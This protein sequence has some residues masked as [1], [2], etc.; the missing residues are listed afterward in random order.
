MKLSM[1]A[2]LLKISKIHEH[3]I[4]LFI[5]YQSPNLKDK[6]YCIGEHKWDWIA[7]VTDEIETALKRKLYRSFQIPAYYVLLLN[8]RKITTFKVFY[9]INYV[10]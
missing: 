1:Y 10:Y 5:L 3:L 8:E 2:L 7:S 4:V 9:I 6:F